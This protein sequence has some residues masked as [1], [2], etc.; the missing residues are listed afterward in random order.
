MPTELFLMPDNDFTMIDRRRAVRDHEC[1]CFLR[2][3]RVTR[4]SST[5]EGRILRLIDS[6]VPV[7][8]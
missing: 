7:T 6:G 1:E 5:I 4:L 3:R 8:T 2:T